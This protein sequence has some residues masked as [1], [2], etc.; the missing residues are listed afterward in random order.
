MTAEDANAEFN[1]FSPH[2]ED[3]VVI[4][5]EIKSQD[6]FWRVYDSSDDPAGPFLTRPE[7]LQN[8]NSKGQVIDKLGLLPEE[9]GADYD[10]IAKVE[11]P[12]DEGITLRQSTVGEITSPDTGESANGGAIQ[13]FAGDDHLNGW[14]RVGSIEDIVN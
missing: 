14:T 7:T 8:L 6:T 2:K 4:D 3:S 10:S 5:F 9:F 12:G 11:V 1:G 13:Y